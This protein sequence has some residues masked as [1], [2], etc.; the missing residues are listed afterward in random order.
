MGLSTPWYWI[1][2]LVY[3]LTQVSVISAFSA[4][5]L[6]ARVLPRSDGGLLFLY[7]WLFGIANFGYAALM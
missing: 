1:H 5:I 6:K 7:L 2:W 3:Y 4:I